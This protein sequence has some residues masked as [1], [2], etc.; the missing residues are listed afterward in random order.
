MWLKESKRL[1]FPHLVSCTEGEKFGELPLCERNETAVNSNPKTFGDLCTTTMAKSVNWDQ[2]KLQ[3]RV[4][5]RTVFVDRFSDIKATRHTHMEPLVHLTVDLFPEI[6]L[7]TASRQQ[8]GWRER[9]TC[10]GTARLE[11]ELR[12]AF[13]LDIILQITSHFW[14]I[15]V[16]ART[17]TRESGVAG[18]TRGR[19]TARGK[20]SA[21]LLRHQEGE[22]PDAVLKKHRFLKS[23]DSR[24]ELHEEKRSS[25]CR[26]V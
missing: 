18:Q 22:P 15:L 23:N 24:E 10:S 19:D 7:V 3:L 20:C 25:T 11:S 12:S 14:I 8:K 26:G 17:Q 4:K 21:Y 2:F 1:T 5:R 13:C 16:K 6:L 9:E